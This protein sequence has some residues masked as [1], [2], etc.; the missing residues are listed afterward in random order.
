MFDSGGILSLLLLVYLNPFRRL[1]MAS[2][3]QFTLP[4]ERFRL[5]EINM[6]EELAAAL[7]G[8]SV[9]VEV[10]PEVPSRTLRIDLDNPRSPDMAEEFADRI[11]A[12]N[13]HPGSLCCL[14]DGHRVQ[15]GQG[16]KWPVRADDC[17]V[18]GCARIP[19]APSEGD[20]SLRHSKQSIMIFHLTPLPPS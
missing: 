13:Y 12:V 10:L 2:T 6:P 17:V 5:E 4:D 11:V 15:D 3:R 19:P 7:L 9:A 16:G 14:P 18:V 20:C 8:Q 1:T